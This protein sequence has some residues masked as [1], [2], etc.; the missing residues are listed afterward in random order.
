MVDTPCNSWTEVSGVRSLSGQGGPFGLDGGDSEARLGHRGGALNMRIALLV[1]TATGME[2]RD[3]D[4]ANVLLHQV[5]SV[6][7]STDEYRCAVVNTLIGQSARLRLTRFPSEI[8]F[9]RHCS[10]RKLMGNVSNA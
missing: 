4:I 7:H 10:V 9:E 3:A 8:R 5:E 1:A 6:K 2:E